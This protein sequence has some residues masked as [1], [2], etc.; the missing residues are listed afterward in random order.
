MTVEFY[1]EQMK[2]MVT[3][4]KETQKV[5]DRFKASDIIISEFT[6]RIESNKSVDME[7]FDNILKRIREEI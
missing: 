4:G 6:K 2:E 7:L 5:D 3:F 1:Q